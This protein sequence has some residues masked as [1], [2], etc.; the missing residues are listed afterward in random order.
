MESRKTVL[1]N[2][3]ARKK[4]DANIEKRLVDTVREG[5]N[6]MNGESSIDVYAL[7]GAKYIAGEKLPC[8]QGPQPGDL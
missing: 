2:L 8:N 1:M 7:P 5:E 3:F 4:G 6:G